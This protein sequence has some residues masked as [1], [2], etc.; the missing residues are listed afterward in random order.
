MILS[1]HLYQIDRSPI[2]QLYPNR[3]GVQDFESILITL[4]KASKYGKTDPLINHIYLLTSE[5]HIEAE[6]VQSIC[7]SCP[8]LAS[9]NPPINF[10]F[11]RTNGRHTCRVITNHKLRL[12]S[13]QLDDAQC[14]IT[15]Y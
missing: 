5:P 8:C 11:R 12:I 3:P 2:G 7:G 6:L 10:Q 1:A 4:G 9:N 13:K 15:Q 14:C